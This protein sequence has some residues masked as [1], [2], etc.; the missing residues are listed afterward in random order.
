MQSRYTAPAA[1]AGVPGRPNGINVDAL[2]AL[3]ALMP[4]LMLRPSMFNVELSVATA[5]GHPGVDE[6]ERDGVDVD[7]VTAPLLGQR[8]GHAD[9]TGL[10]R[11]VVRLP[12]IAVAAR[13]EEMLTT[14]R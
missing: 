10:G 2:A 12:R 3:S 1:S 6:A 9:H 5:L 11:A 8:L 7:L 13:V 4:T 14:L